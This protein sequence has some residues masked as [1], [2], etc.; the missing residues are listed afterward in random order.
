MN[1]LESMKWKRSHICSKNNPYHCGMYFQ[2][3]WFYQVCI[4]AKRRFVEEK[5]DR[6][7]LKT[8]TS[9]TIKWHQISEKAARCD[10]SNPVA[11][12]LNE[13]PAEMYFVKGTN[14]F[15]YRLI[16]NHNNIRSLERRI[17]PHGLNKKNWE[18]GVWARSENTLN[19]HF[20]VQQYL[21]F[22]LRESVSELNVSCACCFQGRRTRY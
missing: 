6:T 2:I 11:I 4:S 16:R 1:I 7:V 14:I 9:K 20:V 15:V 10:I 8:E 3:K 21:S 19:A 18:N 13:K 22:L 17:V 5:K 12:S